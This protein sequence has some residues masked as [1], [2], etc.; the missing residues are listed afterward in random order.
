M[1][2]ADGITLASLSG[3][4]IGQIE[5]LVV[6]DHS[7]AQ[8]VKEARSSHYVNWKI[9]RLGEISGRFPFQVFHADLYLMPVSQER[10]GGS[11]NALGG[12]ALS[13]R[14]RRSA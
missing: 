4:V 9:S 5:N 7:Q 3:I 8:V 10:A 1:S 2:C 14:F 13:S 11:S 12:A 6:V